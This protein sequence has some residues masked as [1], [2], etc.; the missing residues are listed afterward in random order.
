M[1]DKQKITTKQLRTFGIA[2][3][4]FLSA[5]G[6]IQ[7]LKG[8]EP[9]CFWFWGVA[10]LILLT[11]LAVPFVIKPIFQLA[12][13]IAHILGWINTRIILSVIFYFLFTPISLIMKLLGHDPLH[14]KFDKQAKTYWKTRE[15]I[16]FSKENYLRQF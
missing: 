6:L 16:P 15:R 8:N 3:A 13:F 2:L 1:N 14:R 9:T 4:I 11:T 7:F 5:I 12:M 10:A